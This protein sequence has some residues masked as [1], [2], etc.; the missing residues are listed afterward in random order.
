MVLTD[1]CCALSMNE[2]VL[3]TMISASS[4]CATSSAPAWANMPIITSLSTRF[5]GH[6]RLTNPTLGVVGGSRVSTGEDV[7]DMQS[8]YFIRTAGYLRHLRTF[9]ASA[10][11]CC[12]ELQRGNRQEIRVHAVRGNGR[13]VHMRK[14]L[15]PLSEPN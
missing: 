7:E 15:L 9:K 2:Q 13:E 10:Y 5:L 1:S 8:D 6:P 3:T 11:S 14:V 12:Y 4:A